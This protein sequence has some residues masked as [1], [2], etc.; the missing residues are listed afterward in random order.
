MSVQSEGLTMELYIDYSGAKYA[1]ESQTRKP[2]GVVS[3]EGRH[4]LN[5]V[6]NA[7]D[8]L[9]F[10][11]QH[12]KFEKKVK[13]YLAFLLHFYFI[14]DHRSEWWSTKSVDFN[15]NYIYNIIDLL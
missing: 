1:L 5:L 12:K 9:A 2:R 7:R 10:L 3:F 4:K 14:C 15:R 8:T 11:K 13:Q 6:R